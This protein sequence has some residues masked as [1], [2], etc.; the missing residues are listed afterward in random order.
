M[1][2]AG[3]AFGIVGLVCLVNDCIDFL[4]LFSELAHL[5]AITKSSMQSVTLKRPYFFNGWKV[6]AYSIP[7]MIVD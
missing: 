4:S 7:T 2:V 3:L 5:D 1:E 6:L